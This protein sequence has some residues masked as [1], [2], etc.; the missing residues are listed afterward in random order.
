MLVLFFIQKIFACWPPL[1]TPPGE[2][3]PPGAPSE[4]L[5]N[6]LGAESMFLEALKILK[7]KT[8]IFRSVTMLAPKMNPFFYQ[9]CIYFLV[10]CF[11]LKEY[12]FVHTAGSPNKTSDHRFYSQGQYFQEVGALHASYNNSSKFITK[13]YRNHATIA[14]KMHQKND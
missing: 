13:S 4:Y 12:T 3:V 11:I 7:I 14:P 5:R 1:W 2:S 6:T 9:C 10:Y 8:L